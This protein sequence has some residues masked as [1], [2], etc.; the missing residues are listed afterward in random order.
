MLPRSFNRRQYRNTVNVFALNAR[1]IVGKS[2]RSNPNPA[3]TSEL[4]TPHSARAKQD[5]L[6]RVRL[7][8][9]IKLVTLTRDC[10]VR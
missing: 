6:V 3:Q 9:P 5:N 2:D 8:Y 10:C 1:I 4:P 7:C